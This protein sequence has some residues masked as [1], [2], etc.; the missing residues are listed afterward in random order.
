MVAVSHAHQFIFL[1][2]RKTAGTSVEMALEPFCRPGRRRVTEVTHAHV[3]ACGI[4]GQRL[5][6]SADKRPQDKAWP[7]HMA[8][9]VARKRLGDAIWQRYAKVATVRNPF[10]RAVSFY[11][12]RAQRGRIPVTTD[13]DTTRAQF[14]DFLQGPH[15]LAD[16]E[17]VTLDGHW[18]VDH[19]VR[20]E[21]LTDD[22]ARTCQALGL[23]TAIAH[24]LPRTKDTG[25][26]RQRPVPDYFD[27]D[28]VQLVRD[29]CA[30][31]FERGGYGDAPTHIDRAP[32]PPETAHTDNPL[33][34]EGTVT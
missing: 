1:K 11:H 17:I 18:V 5:I 27:A 32:T 21:H 6:E 13:W 19:L 8:A 29:R 30:W 16:D 2:T 33:R 3:G 23:P 7:S 26:D 22:L 34:S 14:R 4:V 24:A 20:V 31:M 9:A 10:D 15:F 28:L 25:G 12:F